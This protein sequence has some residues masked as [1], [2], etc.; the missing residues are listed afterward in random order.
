MLHV[1]RKMIMFKAKKS[2]DNEKRD[3][4]VRETFVG[5]RGWCEKFKTRHGFSLRRIT[6]TPQKDPS[7]PAD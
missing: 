1:S 3:P 6:T 4:A 2:F 7:F 5:G